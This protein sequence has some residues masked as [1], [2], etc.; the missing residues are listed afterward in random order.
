MAIT[1]WALLTLA[2][3][4]V[5]GVG[6]ALTTAVTSL[7]TIIIQF[8]PYLVG[9]AVALFVFKRLENKASLRKKNTTTNLD[10][11]W[12]WRI[13]TDTYN[14]QEEKKYKWKKLAKSRWIKNK[15][16]EDE[17]IAKYWF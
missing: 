16:E 12:P 7:V 15:K 9:M 4:D 5:S 17:A 11:L 2:P 1:S 14:S 10:N 6:T 8:A 3:T 13:D